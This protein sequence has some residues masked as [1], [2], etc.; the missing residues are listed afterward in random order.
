[1]QSTDGAKAAHPDTQATYAKAL[2][3]DWPDNP[4]RKKGGDIGSSC[5]IIHSIRKRKRRWSM[6]LPKKEFFGEERPI[7]QLKGD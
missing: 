2:L 6:T 5:S 4:E 3:R 7:G 1:M